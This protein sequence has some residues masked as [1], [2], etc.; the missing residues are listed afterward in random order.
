[1]KLKLT[2]FLSGILALFSMVSFANDDPYSVNSKIPVIKQGQ[3]YLAG[4]GFDG[5]V[6][7]DDIGQEQG[8]FEG[9]ILVDKNTLSSRFGGDKSTDGVIIDESKYRWPNGRMHYRLFRTSAATNDKVRRAMRY[10]E[11][12][13]HVKFIEIA[14]DAETPYH[15]QIIDYYNQCASVVGRDQDPPGPIKRRWQRMYVGPRCGFSSTVH[16]L[17]HALGMWHEQSRVDRDQFVKI[18]WENILEGKEHNFEIQTNS[19]SVG[20]YDLKSIMHYGYWFFSKAPNNLVTISSKIPGQN[21]TSRN[22]VMSAGDIASINR[23]YPPPPPPPTEAQK[24]AAKL[25]PSI[26]LLLDE[27]EQ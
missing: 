4:P 25:V 18:H 22:V 15:V 12:R 13:T 3:T 8:L 2:Y 24:R 20:P 7:Y 6:T 1:M 17:L 9:D 16:E 5:I 10:I 21:V 11:S 26:M 27:Q 14:E 19:I 23:M